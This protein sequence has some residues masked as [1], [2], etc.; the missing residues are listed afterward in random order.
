MRPE[1]KRLATGV[2][3]EPAMPD[4]FTVHRI[5]LDWL[6]HD[7]AYEVSV[8]A[9][10]PD[11]THY[12][13]VPEG[14]EPALNVHRYAD[15]SLNGL[16]PGVDLQF[17][18][19]RGVLESDW[20]LAR[21]SDHT[22]IRFRITGAELSVD[23]EGAL[24]MR[25]PLGE[26]R[27]AAPIALQQGRDVPARWVV[28]G[29]TVRIE[30]TGYAPTV[31]LVI[32]PMTR[33][34]GT[35]YGGTGV[36]YPWDM[37]LAPNGNVITSGST[38]SFSLVASSGAHQVSFGGDYDGFAYCFSSSGARLW[39][40]YY[41]GTGD[42]FAYAC[43][44]S[45]TGNIFLGGWAQSATNISTPNTHQPVHS[46]M[47]IL[48]LPFLAMFN[49]SGIRQWGTY[50]G[51]ANGSGRIY[52]LAADASNNV[53]ATGYTISDTGYASPG[54][55]QTIAGLG[56]EAFLLKFNSTGQRLWGTYIGGNGN[57]RADA[58]ALLPDGSVLLAGDTQGAPS[59][60]TP[61]A[62]Q[63]TVQGTYDAFL[64]KVSSDGALIWSTYFGG[65][66]G[67]AGDACGV[68]G[69]GNVHLAGATQ[70]TAG[71]ASLGA[72]QDTT[73]GGADGFLARFDSLG[74]FQWATFLGGP[75]GDAIYNSSADAEG[76][77][78]VVGL[79]ISASGLASNDGYDQTLTGNW[80]AFA[81]RFTPTGQRHWGTYYGGLND[82][83]GRGIAARSGDEVYF[84]GFT[85]S[86]NTIA[87][88]GAFNTSYNGGL[89]DGFIVKF[90]GC[91]PFPVAVDPA[92]AALCIGDTVQLTASGGLSQAW[93]PALGLN[94]VNSD[95]VLAFPTI[96]TT[97][98]AK[99]VDSLACRMTTP[100][101]VTVTD[102]DSTITM[103]DSTLTAVQAGAQYQWIDCANGDTLIPGATAQQFQPTANGTYAAI[104]SLN[105]CVD[106]TACTPFALTSIT[107]SPGISGF[108]VFPNP[109]TDE[110][111]FRCRGTCSDVI[112]LYDGVGR[113]VRR[114][115]TTG[116]QQGTIDLR[117][118]PDGL[119]FLELEHA[120]GRRIRFV[121]SSN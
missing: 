29:N 20:L 8:G 4:S 34:W 63:T 72:H 65:N 74:Q 46:G 85:A 24:V 95:T 64:M 15:V 35:Y 9:A 39:S 68:D 66:E 56:N 49:G 101:L 19:R 7:P 62:Y 104:V 76:G 10:F 31:P 26:V 44:T 36:E 112:S 120:R 78:S 41:G 106:T 117:G 100:V 18:A 113:L 116:A 51:S 30:L 12:Y 103:T 118:L 50:N 86:T 21:A 94:T 111:H 38:A 102:V 82:E 79:A 54:A 23:A 97:Y 27:E 81:A 99:C 96:T 61:G 91:A 28:D 73:G 45:P 53:F 42:D 110:L 87:T 13:N 55:M 108:V 84:G 32:D 52:G 89:Y 105:G 11:P 88:P 119:Y 60:G 71:L 90:D 22:K 25:T 33:L 67:E 16:W 93:S 6:A 80:D 48:R 1:T 3:D 75:L 2:L 121:R 115:S 59:I 47:G 17:H 43:C 5:D 40:T 77:I 109:A 98:T 37:T 70:S 69:Y 14:V 114:V 58:C 57:D 107:D 83:I 92:S